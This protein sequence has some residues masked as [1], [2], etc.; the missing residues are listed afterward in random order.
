[1]EVREKPDSDTE[2]ACKTDSDQPVMRKHNMELLLYSPIL[3][4]N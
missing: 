2:A 3:S 4:V 1:M